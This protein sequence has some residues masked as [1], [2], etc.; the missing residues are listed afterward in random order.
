MRAVQLCRRVLRISLESGQLQECWMDR[1]ELGSRKE[2][3]KEQR[4]VTDRQEESGEMRH[5]VDSEV[6][7]KQN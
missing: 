3:R 6:G 5:R 4:N 1:K 7:R 2:A